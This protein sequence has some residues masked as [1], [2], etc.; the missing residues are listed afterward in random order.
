MKGTRVTGLPR[1]SPFPLLLLSPRAQTLQ[2][3][4]FP[5]RFSRVSDFG[6]HRLAE[7]FALPSA[8]PGRLAPKRLLLPPAPL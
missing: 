6:G 7:G 1:A 8:S 3:N 4:V 5:R 2:P